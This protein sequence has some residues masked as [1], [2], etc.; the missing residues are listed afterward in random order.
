MNS[1]PPSPGGANRKSPCITARTLRLSAAGL[2]ARRSP[3][4]LARTLERRLPL[5]RARG[6]V[7]TDAFVRRRW[8]PI[9]ESIPE[10]IGVVVVVLLQ[11]ERDR[12]PGLCQHDG[13]RG[14]VIKL[15]PIVEVREKAQ[16]ART[17]A[18]KSRREPRERVTRWVGGVVLGETGM[19]RKIRLRD[20]ATGNQR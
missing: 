15:M 17:P 16:Q 2:P 4:T 14:V 12:T 10:Q 20:A 19:L 5:V 3:D 8:Q 11:H 13:R 1:G 6:D 18:G 7:H 9:L